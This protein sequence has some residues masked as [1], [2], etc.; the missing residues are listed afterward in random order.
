MCYG[1]VS[2][3]C[4]TRGTSRVTFFLKIKGG[5]GCEDDKRNISLAINETTLMSNELIQRNM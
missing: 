2:C 1:V 5:R 3:S 4:S